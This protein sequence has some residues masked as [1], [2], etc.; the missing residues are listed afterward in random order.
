MRRL[1][2]GFWLLALALNLAAQ[3]AKHNFGLDD[4]ARMKSVSDPQISP[5][6]AWVAYSVRTPDLKEDRNS[7]DIWMT[8]WDGQESVRLTTSKESE[9]TPRWSPD[10]KYLAFLSSRDDDNDAS[11]L[12]L[13]P[14]AGGE[15]EKVTEEKG[16]VEDFDWSPDGKRLVL[17]VSDPDPDAATARTRSPR[18]K[19]TKKPIVI[20][21]YQFKLD[22][23]GY[24]GKLRSHLSILDLATRKVGGP[25]HGRL[26]RAAPGLV[27]RRQDHR[28]R[29]EA[30]GRGRPDGQLGPLRRSSRA[31]A[32]RRGQLTT[33]ERSDNQPDWGSRLA[34]SP[35]VEVDRLRPGR[36]RQAHLLRPAQAGGRPGG[37]RNAASVLTADLD[38]NVLSPEYTADGSAIVFTARGRPGRRPRAHSGGGRA[39]RA[40]RDRAAAWSPASAPANGP[41]RRPD[42]HR[43]SAGR[44][45]RRRKGRR[46]ASALAAERRLA[47]RG[48]PRSRRGDEVQEQGRNR[49]PRVPRQAAGLPGGQDLS[50]HPSPPRRARRA[51]S[52]APSTRSGTGSRPTAMSCSRRIRAGAP[53]E[54][55]S[56]RRRSTRTGATSTPQ[57]V[58]AAVDDAVARGIADPD[59]L[60]VGG[61]SYGSML[62]N[63]VIASTQRFKAATSGAGSSNPLAGYGSDQYIREYEQEL[64]QPW[65]N[66]EGWLKVSYPFVHADR[67]TTPT[68]FL[69]GEEDFNMPHRRLRA[70]VPGAA[71]PRRSD[72]ARDL[73]GPAPRHPQAELRARPPRALPRLVRQVREGGQAGRGGTT[74]SA[75]R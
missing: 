61:W 1:I 20:D 68:L 39:G 9:S 50:H 37:R 67:I 59:R 25:D 64:G 17:V 4:V 44:D 2:F 36:A 48:A 11:Q 23:T 72:A 56:S 10:G 66:L 43:A 31:R 58:L 14:R 5:D 38:L 13:L 7:S 19:K 65:K 30:H 71:E 3:P 33:D 8:R 26:R 27:A 51:S 15:A 53:G 49:D 55:R 45:L 62:T 54:G 46:A 35:D 21:R 69:C 32:P 70:D 41:D 29:L 47:R 57:D 42:G 22:G 16:G 12:W 40:A 34:W 28:L 74:T 63:Y 52:S 24:L 60:A 75:G 73:P 6:G 18:K